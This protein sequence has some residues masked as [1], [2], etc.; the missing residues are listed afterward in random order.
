MNVQFWRQCKT[1]SQKAS[2]LT[3]F[4]PVLFILFIVILLP[5]MGLFTFV[6]GV[7]TIAF[8]TN[9]A[10]RDCGTASTR[11]AA[12]L[13][14]KSIANRIIG[15]PFGKF[16]GLTPSDDS[17]MQLVVLEIGVTSGGGKTEFVGTAPITNINTTDNF[18]EYQVRSTY[19]VKPL[20]IPKS[21]QMN[22]V[23]AS[24]VEHPNG[25]N[26]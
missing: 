19:G 12:I 22:W 3:E 13:N 10:A 14:M 25:L 15:G 21:I 6:C 9:V 11:S 4:G 2:A 24:H 23:S 5:L 8:A 18:Y 7:T 16:S 1:R 26:N 20:F 17:G